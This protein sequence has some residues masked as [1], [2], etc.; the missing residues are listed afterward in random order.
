METAFSMAR[1]SASCGAKK[2]MSY[3]DGCLST[4]GRSTARDRRLDAASRAGFSWGQICILLFGPIHRSR[5]AHRWPRGYRPRA[6]FSIA[7]RSCSPR[8]TRAHARVEER[9]SCGIAHP[10]ELERG[11]RAGGVAD[12]RD[13]REVGIVALAEPVEDEADVARTRAPVVGHFRGAIEI[14]VAR[15]QHGLVQ[16]GVRDVDGDEPALRERTAEVGVGVAVLTDAVRDDHERFAAGS[17][18]GVDPDRHVARTVLI[19]PDG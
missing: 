7:R 1:T 3:S 17:V 5:M 9:L 14:P 18:G 2:A 15:L 8:P 12:D 19:A 16:P 10:G 6:R 4:G 13:A 11:Q